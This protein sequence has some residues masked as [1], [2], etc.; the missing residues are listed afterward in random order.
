MA[1]FA[2]DALEVFLGVDVPA[3][4]FDDQPLI[5]NGVTEMVRRLNFTL[6]WRD[7][8]GRFKEDHRDANSFRWH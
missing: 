1:L 8:V 3:Q 5:A 4:T 7:L 6:A 2:Q